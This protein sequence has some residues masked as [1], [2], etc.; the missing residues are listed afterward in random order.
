MEYAG[1]QAG[2]PLDWSKL[3]GGLVQT[4]QDIGADRERQRQ[5]LDKLQLDNS[6]ILQNSELG[7]S[8]SLNELILSGSN[9]GRTKMTE[10]NKM[11]KNGQITPV[12]YRNRINNLM[13]SWSTFANV[14]KIFDTQLQEAMK[15]QQADENGFI[16]GSGLEAELNLKLAELGDL[17]NKKV[18]IDSN[19][20]N[21]VIGSLD[22]KGLF[23]PSSVIDVRSIA[24]PGN[25]IDNRVDLTKIVDA[26]TKGW[27]NWSLEKGMTTTTDP[28][29]NPAVQRA[30]LD[31]AAGV[32]SNPRSATS[33]LKDNT[34][35][36]YGFYYDE[37]DLRSKLQDR[38]AKENELNQQMGKPKLTGEALDKFVKSEQNKFILLQKDDQGVYQPN[39]T[40]DQFEEAKKT[41]LDAID[42]RLL[43]KVDQD[44]PQYV[45]SRGGGDG[46][47]SGSGDDENEMLAGY[48]ATL[49]AWG[50]D[51]KSVMANP[52]DQSKWI[53]GEPDFGS[54]EGGYTYKRKPGG[55]IEVWDK[56]QRNLLH[57]ASKPSDLAQYVYNTGDTAEAITKWEKARKIIRQG[58]PVTTTPS[59]SNKVKFN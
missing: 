4:I 52:S 32:L 44:E 7:K 27:E 33:V 49:R 45:S 19:N 50:Y 21:F 53:K 55:G 34:D 29:Q 22:E 23:N 14:A 30:R 56:E 43:R 31:L 37:N 2:T 9:D 36:T 5:E 48:R 40:K 42:A 51:L 58:G 25:M 54:L 3:T 20:G 35:G 16:P 1:Y 12:E 39:L 41:V 47:G 59:T 11:L 57:V 18:Q 8:Q 17:R 24:K 10:W 28:L 46:S 6:K 13:D 15:R 38:I 26:G